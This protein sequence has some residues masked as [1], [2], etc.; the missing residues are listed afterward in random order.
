MKYVQKCNKCQRFRE[1][2]HTNCV[3][4]KYLMA[5]INY[6]TKWIEAEPL[7]M[8]TTEKVRKF[9]WKRIICRHGVPHHLVNDN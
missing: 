4:Q 3:A 5:A 2:K 1:L 7:P 8:I 9:V 6:F